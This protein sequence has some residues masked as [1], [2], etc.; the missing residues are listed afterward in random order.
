MRCLSFHTMPSVLSLQVGRI[1]ALGP[2][3]VPSAF[4]K[5]TLSGVA[6]AGTLG[7]QGDEQADLTVHG[8]PDKAIYFYPSEHFS[9]WAD[10]VPK[11][12]D[13]LLPGS[14]GENVTTIGMDED[15]VS[16]GDVLAIG[17]AQLQVTQPRQPCFKLGLRFADNTLGRIM[18]RT[19][20][21]GWYVRVLREGEFQAGDEI[22]VIRRPSPD[23]TIA[24]FNQ[25][26]VRR[27]AA[28][29]DMKVLAEME[30]LP[31]EWRDEFRE[32]LR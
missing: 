5:Q 15:N 30:G 14:F 4:I 18:M 21:T 22:K 10:D 25:L 28:P 17:S 19:N 8:G 24:R 26:I 3:M 7:L 11:H 16:I 31:A 2:G 9:L 29:E 23:W 13:L 27:S 6:C 1:A 20:R 32:A 12:R